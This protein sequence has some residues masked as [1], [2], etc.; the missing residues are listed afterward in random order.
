MADGHGFADYLLYVD[1]RTVG[2]L[3][4]K[5][6]GFTFERREAA[7]CPVFKGTPG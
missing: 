5:P 7:G 2:A 1:K 3:E 4:A 6:V